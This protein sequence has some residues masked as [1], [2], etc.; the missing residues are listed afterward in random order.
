M[1][2]SVEAVILDWAGTVVDFGSFA[3][4]QIFVDAFAQAFNFKISL[5]E[6]RGPMGMGK[7]DHIRAL[8]NE[9][10]IR[11]RWTAQFGHPPSEEEAQHIYRTFMPLQIAQVVHFAKPIEGALDSPISER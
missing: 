11:T 7:I 9:P 4:T 2:K 3:P 1:N 8:L 10:N 6:A 5:S